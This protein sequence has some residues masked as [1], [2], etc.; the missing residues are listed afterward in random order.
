MWSTRAYLSKDMGKQGGRGPCE[1]R[2][3]AFG[4]EEVVPGQDS[5]FS[6][7]ISGC[8]GKGRVS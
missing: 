4:A 8:E 7:P 1:H 3:A 6:L 2:E 5:K